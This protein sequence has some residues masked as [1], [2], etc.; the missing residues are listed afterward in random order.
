AMA[1]LLVFT[2][3]LPVLAASAVI[4]FGK[5]GESALIEWLGLTSGGRGWVL[6]AGQ[7]LRFTAATGSIVLA[8]ALIYYWGPNR[9][10]VFR[11]VLPGAILATV[12]W[13]LATLGFG[14][15]VRHV[16][17]YNVLYGSVGAGLALLVWMYVLALTVLLGCEFNAARE[18]PG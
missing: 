14:W 2:S 18:T 9:R 7:A 4:V 16:A 5:R 11:R 1:M 15:Y 8:N 12:L 17:N 6:L 10:Q 3:A 13:L